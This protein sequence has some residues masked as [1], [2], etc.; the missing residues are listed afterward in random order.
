MAGG[1]GGGGWKEENLRT[2]KNMII[3]VRK[4]N[5][6]LTYFSAGVETTSS[7]TLQTKLYRVA[8][9]SHKLLCSLWGS[10]GNLGRSDSMLQL[11]QVSFTLV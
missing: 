7:K 9:Q 3:S 8:A 6:M 11:T 2:N 10:S 1:G 4:D 5:K